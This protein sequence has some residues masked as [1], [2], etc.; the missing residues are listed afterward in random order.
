ME[1][2]NNNNTSKANIFWWIA[3]TILFTIV[4]GTAPRLYYALVLI[5][6][7]LTELGFVFPMDP[8]GEKVRF[9]RE[10]VAPIKG[11]LF[12]ISLIGLLPPLVKDIIEAYRKENLAAAIKFRNTLLIFF[13]LLIMIG[14]GKLSG[15]N[16]EYADQSAVVFEKGKD[17][18]LFQ[19][20]LMPATAYMLFFRGQIFFLIFSILCTFVMVYL[21]Q[22]WFVKNN[23][24]LRNWELISILT[25]GFLATK[26]QYPGSPDVFVHS[27]VLILF[28]FPLGELAELSLLAL[29]IASHEASIILFIAIAACFKERKSAIKYLA[30][31]LIYIFIW[32]LSIRFDISTLLY[33][34]QIREFSPLQTII[35]NPKLEILGIF[36]ANKLLWIPILTSL[37]ILARKRDYRT[38]LQIMSL[39]GSGFVMTLFGVDTIRMFEWSFITILIS[40][41]IVHEKNDVIFRKFVSIILGLNLLIAPL[42][43]DLHWVRPPTGIYNLIYSLFGL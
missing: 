34:P 21:A 19:R 25:S 11:L 2:T 1:A 35:A 3:V 15:G 40:I 14:I 13:I 27:L 22:L 26:L 23:I 6:R 5:I 18:W 28:I 9:L 12:I 7:Q 39:I 8:I 41:K 36:Y 31:I 33:I 32:L 43:V 10:F 38:A 24:T 30:V 37:V 20:F 4:F 16:L 29:A 17:V 42:Y